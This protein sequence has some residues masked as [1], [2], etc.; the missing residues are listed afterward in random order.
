MTN[1]FIS[2]SLFFFLFI[3]FFLTGDPDCPDHVRRAK[4]INK[5]IADAQ[6]VLCLDEAFESSGTS[7]HDE[8]E[9]S[10]SDDDDDDDVAA[11]DSGADDGNVVGNISGVVIPV[12]VAH[13]SP[14]AILDASTSV[15]NHAESNKNDVQ[16]AVV[17]TNIASE[18]GSDA[19]MSVD[20]NHENTT[21]DVQRAVNLSYSTKKKKKA[22]AKRK[23]SSID[24]KGK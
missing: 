10:S 3:D 13:C 4:R 6:G 21:K 22:V 9:D 17:S 8:N 2:C 19:A 20:N 23:K 16:S 1:S 5:A 24:K 12:E 11:D 15:Y 7:V 18:A 14:G